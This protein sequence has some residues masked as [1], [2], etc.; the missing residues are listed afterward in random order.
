MVSRMTRTVMVQLKRRGFAVHRHIGVRR[1]RLLAREGVEVVFDVG[2]AVGAYG[3]ELR[4]FGY[5]GRI[6]SV[7]PMDEPFEQL[8]AATATDSRWTARQCALGRVA[9]HAAINVASQG[10]S[11]SLLPLADAHRRAAPYVEYVGTQE[12]RVE[13]LD[14]IAGQYLADG[15]RAFLKLDTQGFEREVLAGATETLMRCAGLQLE[16]SFVPLY[17]G[18]PLI[19]EM[20]SYV[21]DRGFRMVALD[22]GFTSPD[23]PMLQADGVFFRMPD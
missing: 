22:P 1:Q 20:L 17:E 2:A 7:E 12:I 23:G 21:Y 15:E 16:L 14:D 10:D 19:D 4:E 6:V 13:R 11:S 9:G 8:A 18:G 3:R 5:S